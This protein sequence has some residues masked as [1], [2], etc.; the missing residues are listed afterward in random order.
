MKR[1]SIWEDRI[2]SEAIVDAYGSIP[3]EQALRWYYL[4][5]HRRLLFGHGGI[6]HV[7]LGRAFYPRG[8]LQLAAD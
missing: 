6:V 4:E 8:R 1:H 3:E 7:G 2:H 5:D